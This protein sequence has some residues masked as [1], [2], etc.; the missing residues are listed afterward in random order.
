MKQKQIWNE[1]ADLWNEYKTSNR[2]PVAEDFLKNSKGNILDL[3]CGSGRNFVKTDAKI[4][5][6]DF[7]EKMLQHAKIQA[8][9]LDIQAEFFVSEAHDLPFENNFFDKV[10]AIAVL[11]CI[12]G[13]SKREKTLKEIHR[14]L[15]PKGKALITVWNKSSKR[16]KNK[17]KEIEAG[18]TI[19]D[20][21]V[22]RYYY[23]YD[24]E[25]LEKDLIKAG[26]KITKHNHV[27][28]ARNIVL[29]IQKN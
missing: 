21:K 25:E 5:G 8:K 15:K 6:V 18:W 28:I 7:S 23:I 27:D 1:I 10:I 11:H 22:K 2:T 20:K 26:F 13:K 3:G 16:W 12:E 24:Y 4:Y 14:V 9:K 29:E 19:G 17:P